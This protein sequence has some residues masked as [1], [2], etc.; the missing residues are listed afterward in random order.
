MG[1]RTF[2]D[3]DGVTWQ[4]WDVYPQLAERR[5]VARRIPPSSLPA[6][7]R[8]QRSAGDRRHRHEV[9]VSVREGYEHGWLAFDSVAGSRRVAPIPAHWDALPDDSLIALCGRAVEA[10]RTRRRLIE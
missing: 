4:V 2:I 9:R 1:H 10:A 7:A 8:D 3:R 6:G 5:R